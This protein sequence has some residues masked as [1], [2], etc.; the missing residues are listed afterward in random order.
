MQL[1]S[2]HHRELVYNVF[3]QR[4]AVMS[5]ENGLQKELMSDIREDMT[6]ADL[7]KLLMKHFV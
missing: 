3:T 5:E 7:A 4:A 2:L 6:V 1:A